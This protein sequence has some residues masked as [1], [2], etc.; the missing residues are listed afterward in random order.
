MYSKLPGLESNGIQDI[1][2]PILP[3]FKFNINGN[4]RKH[5]S[6]KG[7]IHVLNLTP[8]KRYIIKIDPGSFDHIAWVVK[9]TIPG[10]IYTEKSHFV[11]NTHTAPDGYFNYLWIPTFSTDPI[12]KKSPF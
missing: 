10:S 6:K 4:F 11:E 12:R 2:E 5:K 3:N 7:G 9:K 1:K 8:Y